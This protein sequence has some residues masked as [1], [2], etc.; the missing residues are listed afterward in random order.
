MLCLRPL[1]KL[2]VEIF[3]CIYTIIVAKTYGPHPRPTSRSERLVEEAFVMKGF[4]TQIAKEAGV[5]LSVRIADY[6]TPT[7]L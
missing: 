1:L 5:V 6:P 2:F 7:L 4:P 3:F